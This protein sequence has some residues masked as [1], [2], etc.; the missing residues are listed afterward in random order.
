MPTEQEKLEANI[1]VATIDLL[2]L[3]QKLPLAER[4]DVV[5]TAVSR[6]IAFSLTEN[7]PR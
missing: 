4:Y 7:E 6:L 1:K 3:I 5:S 2:N